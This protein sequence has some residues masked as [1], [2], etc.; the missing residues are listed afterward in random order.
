MLPVVFF[1]VFLV[2]PLIALGRVAL[3][4]E[5]WETV[6]SAG[7]WEIAGLA[8]VQ[9]LASVFLSLILGVPIAGVLSRYLFPGR[10]LVWALVTVPFVLPTVVV[11]LGFQSLLGGFL[12]PGILLVV[13]AHAYI[14]IA[15]V[16]RVVGAKWSSILPQQR[17]IAQSLGATP[18][19]VFR[20]V[21]LPLLR[22]SLLAA[23]CIV[24][25]FSFTSLGI[26]V[27][28]GDGTSTRT[29][30][31]SILRQTSVLLNFPGALASA[32]LQVV[33]VSLA[34][35]IA[36]RTGGA[37]VP[38][39][40]GNTQL[41]HSLSTPRNRGQKLA[42]AAVILSTVLV[43]AA[44]ISSIVWDSIAARG[45]ATLQWW[46]ALPTLTTTFAGVGSPL[47]AVLTSVVIAL[48][49]ALI[50]ALIGGATAIAVMGRNPL[51]AFL[52][53]IPLGL[54][55]ATVGLGTLLA[56]GRPPFDLRATGLLIPLAHSLVAIPL[57]VA[58][59]APV[60]RSADPRRLIV[61]SSLGA[62]P[63]RA[64]WTAYGS[65]IRTVMLAAGGLAGAVSLGEFGAA[66][67]LARADTPTIP[68]Q[69]AKL[70]SKPGEQAYATAAVL[71]VLLIAAT[72]AL[73]I[74]VDRLNNRART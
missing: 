46:T 14:N 9:S 28:L 3:T 29:L 8:T 71:S 10:T 69:I 58:I 55:A 60:L 37:M 15:V 43:I 57:V 54:S 2:Y 34:L 64:W 27:I 45:N 48:V 22:P 20:T 67:F 61:A 41:A 1:A 19:H 66:S 11:A 44:P 47:E 13:L 7:P 72:M 12:D 18:W 17:L 73:M 6:L 63:S 50:A 52:T 24:F 59:A 68:L 49:T 16:V 53:L 32:I 33:V 65:L 39:R 25:V 30:E 62:P 70:L 23:S 26:V 42:I 31:Q 40:A 36:A 38:T 21:S 51:L 74:W 4:E 5:T 56:F 35:L